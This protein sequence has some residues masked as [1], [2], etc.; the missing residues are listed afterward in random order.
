M[1]TVVL[2]VS[3]KGAAVVMG[4]ASCGK[5]SVGE[6]LA[7][8]LSAH[9][10]E[11]D[12]LHPASNV[13]KMSAGNP[14]TDEDRWPWLAAVGGAL[15]GREGAIGSC[16]ALKRVYRE[17]IAKAA[18]RRVYFIY[19]SGSRELLQDRINAR[20]GH[21]MP[22]SL[23]DSQLRTLEEPGADEVALKLDIAEPVD[24][25]A[26]KAKAWLLTH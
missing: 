14:L 19:L 13:A 3:F 26:E 22:P 24:V 25:L 20:Q 8:K 7:E 9:F 21:F 23:L 6:L 12:R 4:V 17:A 1:S 11:G 18:Q 15:A 5:T 2:P 10:V 16:S